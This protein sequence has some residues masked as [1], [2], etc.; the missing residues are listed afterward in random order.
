MKHGL[1]KLLAGL[2]VQGV[3]GSTDTTITGI[4]YDSRRAKP[5]NLF[6]CIEGFRQDGHD[7]IPEAIEKGCTAVVVQ[8]DVPVPEGVT[9]VRVPDTRLALAHLAAAFYHHPSRKLRLIGVTG[10]NGKTTTTHLIAAI[11]REAGYKIGLIG[12][13]HNRIGEE[14]FPVERTTPEALDLQELFFR[15]VEAGVDYC[16]MEVSSHALSLQRVAYSEFDL[17]VFTNISQDHLDFHQTLD[18]YLAAK[19]KL[20][21]QLGQPGAKRGTKAAVINVDDPRGREVAGRC[22]VPCLGFGLGE[23]ADL[24]AVDVEMGLQGVKF[25]ARGQGKELH[26]NLKLTGIFSVY[27]A[28]AAI[29]VGLTEGIEPEVIARALAR[30]PGVPGR[31]ESIDEGQDFS[32]IVDYAHTPDSLENVLKAAAEFVKGRRIVVFGCGGDRDRTKRP[33]MGRIAAENAD[34]VIIT[35]DNPRSEDPLAIIADIEPGVKAGGKGAAV[36]EVIPDR[37][38]A[39]AAAIA[40]ARKGDMVILA[41]KGH[42]TY[43]I[44]GDKTLPFDDREVAREALRRKI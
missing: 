9:L 25:T 42:E 6:V 41:G 32:V 24:R 1:G 7:F 33:I 29:G 39:I 36:Y 37:K 22:P 21:T 5:G 23:E 14:T 35:S 15:M 27:N 13:I 4:T 10:T 8:K 16:V 2:E 3:S 19:E 30:V 38:E 18:D 12:T 34:H 26:L 43:Q 44:I 20:F 17:G 40:M 28:L 31:F 11:L